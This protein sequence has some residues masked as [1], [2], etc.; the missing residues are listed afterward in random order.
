M[1]HPGY[2][3]ERYVLKANVDLTISGQGTAV[4]TLDYSATTPR[5]K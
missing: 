1:K 2:E 4:S 3:P 5:T